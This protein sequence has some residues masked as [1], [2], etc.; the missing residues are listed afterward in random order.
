MRSTIDRAGSTAGG[1]SFSEAA[2]PA[3]GAACSSVRCEG[4]ECRL[5]LPYNSLCG[6][7]AGVFVAAAVASRLL[8]FSEFRGSPLLPPKSSRNAGQ[9]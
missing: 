8:P 1:R 6:A 7:S 5:P 2:L 3:A 9:S 4:Y